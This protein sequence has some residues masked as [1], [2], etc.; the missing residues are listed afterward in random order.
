MDVQFEWNKKQ[1]AAK[2]TH[3]SHREMG[4]VNNSENILNI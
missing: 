1:V 3:Y 2:E 4:S